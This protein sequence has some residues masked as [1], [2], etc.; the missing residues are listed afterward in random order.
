MFLA[1]LG[2]NRIGPSF[3]V[4]SDEWGIGL[5]DNIVLLAVFDDFTL[6]TPW[7]QFN[8]VNGWDWGR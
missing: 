6:L 7:M 8:L 1:D 3:R 4:R 2:Q 5:D